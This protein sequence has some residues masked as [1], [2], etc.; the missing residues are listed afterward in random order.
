MIGKFII[1]LLH[2]YCLSRATSLSL[3]LFLSHSLS[4]SCCLSLSLSLSFSLTLSLFLLSFISY[5]PVHAFFHSSL[6]SLSPCLSLSISLLSLPDSMSYSL[7]IYL[8]SS[9]SLSGLQVSSGTCRGTIRR[10]S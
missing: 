1:A 4:L 8:N 10:E 6:L 2:S 3:S 9:S 5:L 7:S